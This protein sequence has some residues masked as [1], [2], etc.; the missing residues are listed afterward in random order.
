MRNKITRSQGFVSFLASLFSIL[1][2]LVFGFT[3]RRGR[4]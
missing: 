2:G 3:V 1:C 4:R